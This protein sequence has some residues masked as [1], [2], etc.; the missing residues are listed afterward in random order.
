MSLIERLNQIA[1]HDW[2]VSLLGHVSDTAAEAVVRITE[3]EAAEQ[4]ARQEE[5][6]ALLLFLE[7]L[8][9]GMELNSIIKAIRT[10]AE[11]RFTKSVL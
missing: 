11:A 8:D 9:E 6:G 7:S 2:R 4:R 5:R 3:L 1:E 10:A